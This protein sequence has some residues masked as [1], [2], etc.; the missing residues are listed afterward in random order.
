MNDQVEDFSVPAECN[1][2]VGGCTKD[3]FI[4]YPN[5]AKTRFVLRADLPL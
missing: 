5:P 3:K 1:L 4:V 2:A